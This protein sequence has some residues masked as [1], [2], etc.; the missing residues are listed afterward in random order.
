MS[1]EK[2]FYIAKV[3]ADPENTDDVILLFPEEMN[4]LFAKLFGQ[5]Q[6]VMIAKNDDDNIVMS[7]VPEQ[8]IK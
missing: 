4:K 5:D 1:N 3:V 8:L 7:K 6:Y 2:E